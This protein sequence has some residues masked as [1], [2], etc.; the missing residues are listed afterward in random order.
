MTVGRR[1]VLRKII[2]RGQEYGHVYK[3]L[4]TRG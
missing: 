2:A 3:T 4:S 1:V